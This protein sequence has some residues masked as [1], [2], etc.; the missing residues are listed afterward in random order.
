MPWPAYFECT[1]AAAAAAAVVAAAV[2]FHFVR[3]I[4]LRCFLQ[5]LE[6]FYLYFILMGRWPLLFV[7]FVDFFNSVCS[8]RSRPG[9]FGVQKAV[10]SDHSSKLMGFLVLCPCDFDGGIGEGS[11]C[12]P[13]TS[14]PAAT[15]THRHTPGCP[16]DTPKHVK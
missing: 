7:V 12:G 3:L 14:Q 1:A 13:T 8:R 16:K 10:D 11:D 6:S 2:A 5:S 15:G 9:G 4:F